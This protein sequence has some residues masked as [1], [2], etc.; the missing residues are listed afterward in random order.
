MGARLLGAAMLLALAAA[1]PSAAETLRG[2]A[3][4][5]DGDTLELA[6]RV[7]RIGGI[8]APEIG[9]L[10]RD[11]AGT[12]FDCGRIVARALRRLVEGRTVTCAGGSTDPWGRL[13]ARCLADGE[14]IGARMVAEGLAFAF[15]KFSDAYLAEQRAAAAARRG[16]WAGSFEFPWDW[17]VTRQAELAPR[18][19]PAPAA[20]PECKIKGNITR[21]GRRIYHVPDGRDYAATRIDPGR[22]ERWF[23]DEA[24]ARRAGFRRAQ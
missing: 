8:D 16:L 12:A 2:P 4:V 23:C 24:E 5:R 20:P 17:R 10:C 6:G 18:P 11:G 14:D 15:E 22:G 19:G 13:V 9:Q 1:L 7:V 3:V 21:D